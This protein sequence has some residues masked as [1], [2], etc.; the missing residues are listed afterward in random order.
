MSFY[1]T[2][3]N[4][5]CAFTSKES[6]DLQ[7]SPIITDVL[8]CT[9]VVIITLLKRNQHLVLYLWSVVL[10]MDVLVVILPGHSWTNYDTM[11]LLHVKFMVTVGFLLLSRRST[12]LTPCPFDFTSTCTS[13]HYKTI[14]YSHITVYSTPKIYLPSGVTC[15]AWWFASRMALLLH[16]AEYVVFLL[17]V[18]GRM[19]V[20]LFVFCWLWWCL[21]R[22]GWLA[23]VCVCV[24]VSFCTFVL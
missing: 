16:A 20:L 11:S 22:L 19:L 4:F 10:F 17:L 6:D 23:C 21:V 1:V 2:V 7:G 9:L 24:Q 3:S 8:T 15:L 18:V 14:V 12:C 13:I 5:Q